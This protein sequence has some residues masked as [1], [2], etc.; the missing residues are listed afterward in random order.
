MAS[1]LTTQSV[2]SRNDLNSTSAFEM[3]LLFTEA[4][5]YYLV[6]TYY[7]NSLELNNLL[8]NATSDQGNRD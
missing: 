6:C 4:Q 2:Y 5:N 7:D 8:K 3:K 1:W